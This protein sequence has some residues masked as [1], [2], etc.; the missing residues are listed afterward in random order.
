MADECKGLA[1]VHEWVFKYQVKRKVGMGRR[2]K[3]VQ[4]YDAF[5]CR[6]C[7]N[8]VEDKAEKRA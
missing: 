7:R 2:R 6:W 1:F 5:Y 3:R 8:T 4:W